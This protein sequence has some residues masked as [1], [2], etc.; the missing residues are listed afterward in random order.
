MKVIM[1]LSL[2]IPVVGLASLGGG[3]GGGRRQE[4]TLNGKA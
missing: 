4:I 2:D 1:C 3:G